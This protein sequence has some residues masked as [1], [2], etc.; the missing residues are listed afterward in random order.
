[1]IA[2]VI[3]RQRGSDLLVHGAGDDGR[4]PGADIL[5]RSIVKMDVA[6][7]RAG[8]RMTEQL[9]DGSEADAVRDALRGK[10]V[11]AMSPKT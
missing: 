1:M 9:S 10:G 8:L 6:V 3:R 7:G 4:G 11:P 2:R 5:Q